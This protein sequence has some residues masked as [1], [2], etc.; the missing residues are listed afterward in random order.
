MR[1]MAARVGALVVALVGAGS[2]ASANHTV[3]DFR[4]DRFAVDGG[5]D[6]DPDGQLDIVE[7]FDDPLQY[8]LW[9]PVSGM[10]YT[11]DGFLHLS[12]PGSHVPDAYGALPGQTIDVTQIAYQPR[13]RNGGGSFTA[14]TYWA[15]PELNRGDYMHFTF[16]GQATSASGALIY[17]ALS[18]SL[19]NG[20]A[21]GDPT[22]YDVT[23]AAV[24]IPSLDGGRPVRSTAV[25]IAPA[26]IA[27]QVVLALSFD[28]TADSVMG[29]FSLDGGQTFQQPFRPQPVFRRTTDA[30]LLMGADP[31]D[32][33]DAAPPAPGASP[34]PACDPAV[35]VQRARIAQHHIR[36]TG[37][38]LQA[39]LD[40]P[41]SR[42]GDLHRT[43]LEIVID[44]DGG[45][46]TS[47]TIPGGARGTGCD[48]RDG[49]TTRGGIARYRNVSSALPP[50]CVPSSARGLQRVRINVRTGRIVLRV[51]PLQDAAIARPGAASIAITI[52]KRTAM[53]LR[54]CIARFACSRRGRA[55]RCR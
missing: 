49:W 39:K 22:M 46:S 24:H 41:T 6:G 33:P 54:P 55:M 21:E 16:V 29:A 45:P 17:E 4:I 30:F 51:R 52:G 13:F 38:A 25:K 10:P 35:A 14:W 26:D 40:V 8:F 53:A 42:V 12:S 1:K 37:Y 19:Y 47:F 5:R 48:P 11:K 27:G 50:T 44:Q 20:T 43:G 36:P 18:M 9:F 23:Q 28:D 3:F 15:R 7:E 34:S 31:A 32:A 2:L